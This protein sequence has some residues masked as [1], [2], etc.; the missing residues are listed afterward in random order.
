ME[1]KNSNEKIAKINIVK[2]LGYIMSGITDEAKCI[3]GLTSK[4]VSGNYEFL[5]SAGNDSVIR[6]IVDEDNPAIKKIVGK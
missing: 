5:L 6:I 1:M 4:F 2:M 3:D